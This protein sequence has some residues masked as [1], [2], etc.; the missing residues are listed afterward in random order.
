MSNTTVLIPFQ[1][2]SHQIRAIKD[3]HGEPWIVAKDVC[4]VLDLVNVSMALSALDDD[5]KMTLTNS[6]GHSGQRGGAQFYNV[7]NESGLYALIF[8]SRK[9]EARAFRKWVTSEVL[10]AIRK[11]GQYH[12]QTAPVSRPDVSWEEYTGLLRDKITLLELQQPKRRRTP[13]PFTEEDQAEIRR[14]SALGYSFR[15]I[16]EA[17]DRSS[18]LVSMTLRNRGEVEA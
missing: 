6:D 8:K 15:E 5:E 9:P 16:C 13:R 18:A 1:F 12:R 17:V 10:P 3:E 11:T 4:A 7:I 14:L 2:Q